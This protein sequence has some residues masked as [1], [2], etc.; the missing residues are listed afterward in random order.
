MCTSLDMLILGTKMHFWIKILAL[1]GQHNLPTLIQ[2]QKM[3]VRLIAMLESAKRPRR[4]KFHCAQLKCTFMMKYHT[5]N[6]L[7][8]QSPS[9]IK[10]FR[11]RGF[12]KGKIHFYSWKDLWF[13]ACQSLLRLVMR[14]KT[15]NFEEFL[16]KR[17]EP[18][19][20]TCC[21]LEVLWAT[22]MYF[23]F[24]ETSKSKYFGARRWK[25]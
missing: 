4:S 3:L 16:E 20:L 5:L 14:P 11:F 10:L 17:M 7:L 24:L 2:S 13:T 25:A 6:M 18:P 23:T 8:D 19:T 9:G 22:G 12:Q 21:N 1:H 15:G